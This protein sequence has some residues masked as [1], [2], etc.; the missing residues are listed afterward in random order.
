[1]QMAHEPWGQSKTHHVIGS[2]LVL[3]C[4]PGV[5]Q[6]QKTESS[7]HKASGNL[8]L[9]TASSRPGVKRN[10]ALH[11]P[12]HFTEEHPATKRRLTH[13]RGQVLLRI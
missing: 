9:P 12:V 6:A 10:Q 5:A 2:Y 11:T 1:M 8:G 7:F 4:V 3:L 13:N